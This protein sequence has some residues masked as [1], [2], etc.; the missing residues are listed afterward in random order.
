MT[1]VE[2]I[3]TLSVVAI[4]L[5]IGAPSFKNAL[6]N[7]SIG[8]AR[9]A[10]VGDLNFARVAAI[11]SRTRVMVCARKSATSCGSDWSNGWLVYE[12]DSPTGVA[13]NLDAS[14]QVLRIQDDT[15]LKQQNIDIETTIRSQSASALLV[16]DQFAFESRGRSGVSGLVVFCDSRGVDDARSIVIGAAGT[17]RTELERNGAGNR[18][19]PW[20]GALQCP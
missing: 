4:I 7:G 16:P 8:S 19:D 20:G 10:L 3:I 17:I 1:L 14:E 11:K 15:D 6:M 13:F 5:G 12:D 2:L 9:S 18:I